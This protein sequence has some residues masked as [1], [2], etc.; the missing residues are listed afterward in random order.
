MFHEDAVR[1]FE[2]VGSYSMNNMFHCYNGMM[3]TFQLH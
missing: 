3:A 1:N 2:S